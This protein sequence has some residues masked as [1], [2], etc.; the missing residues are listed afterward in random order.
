MR[1][2][3]I[4]YFSI[5]FLLISC[6][7]KEIVEVDME[8]MNQ[9]TIPLFILEEGIGT[10]NGLLIDSVSKPDSSGTRYSNTRD[11]VEVSVVVEQGARQ[12]QL[13]ISIFSSDTIWRYHQNLDLDVFGMHN[14]RWGVGSGRGSLTIQFS[15]DSITYNLFQQCGV[16]CTSGESFK[17]KKE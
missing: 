14:N 2:K 9:D 8:E 16:V 17:L 5:L 12:E 6:N 1:L 3:I 15:P 4:F 7:E 13:N 10:Y 11:S